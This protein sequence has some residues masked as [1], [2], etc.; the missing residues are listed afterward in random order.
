MRIIVV[1][2]FEDGSYIENI[3]DSSA[4]EIHNFDGWIKANQ[5][6]R[7]QEAEWAEKRVAYERDTLLL[8]L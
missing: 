8:N 6:C 5:F 4:W 3:I 1:K 2:P 7:V